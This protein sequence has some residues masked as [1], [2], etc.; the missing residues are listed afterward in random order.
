[1]SVVDL[2]EKTGGGQGGGWVGGLA[3]SLE[4]GRI[5]DSALLTVS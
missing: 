4:G 1:M 2:G 5:S 3:V